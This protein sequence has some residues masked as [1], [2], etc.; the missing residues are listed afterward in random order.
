MLASCENALEVVTD[1]SSPMLASYKKVL[2]Y[3]VGEYKSYTSLADAV[4]DINW[5]SAINSDQASG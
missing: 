4:A 3:V 1:N 2:Q 5:E